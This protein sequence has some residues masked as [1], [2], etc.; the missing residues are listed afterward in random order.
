MNE[1][2]TLSQPDLSALQISAAHKI[3][4]DIGEEFDGICFGKPT[5][6]RHSGILKDMVPDGELRLCELVENGKAQVDCVSVRF[7]AKRNSAV[8]NHVDAIFF[9]AGTVMPIYVG[10]RS[11]VNA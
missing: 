1:A 11:H 6:E 10:K 5:F 2:A 4:V 8:E 7:R 9:H 3:S